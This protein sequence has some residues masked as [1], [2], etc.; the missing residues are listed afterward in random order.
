MTDMVPVFLARTV[1]GLAA[2]EDTLLK[3]DGFFQRQ[4]HFEAKIEAVRL[5]LDRN[6][7]AKTVF[8]NPDAVQLLIA[9]LTAES[10]L[11][12][13]GVDGDG[14]VRRQQFVFASAVL[15]TTDVAMRT[16]RANPPLLRQLWQYVESPTLLDPVQ[17][18][19]WCRCAGGLLLS[20]GDGA[21]PSGG[22]EPPV[23]GLGTLLRHLLRHLHSDAVA[24][25]L[26]CLL[27]VL[28]V[29]G[30]ASWLTLLAGLGRPCDPAAWIRPPPPSTLRPPPPTR[31]DRPTAPAHSAP[32]APTPHDSDAPTPTIDRRGCP[33]P[34]RSVLGEVLPFATELLLYSPECADNAADVLRSVCDAI[35]YH[36]DSAALQQAFLE[37]FAPLLRRTL[38]VCLPLRGPPIVSAGA[39]AVGRDSRDAGGGAG[40]PNPNPGGGRGGGGRGGG[41]GGRGG[42]SGGRGRGGGS[43]GAARVA[44][45]GGGG[46]DSP[47]GLSSPLRRPTTALPPIATSP[48]KSCRQDCG[49]DVGI[50][51]AAEAPPASAAN[52]QFAMSL[53]RAT[54]THAPR[55]RA[56]YTSRRHQHAHTPRKRHAHAT[57]R[58]RGRCARRSSSSR[59]AGRWAAAAATRAT[60]TRARPS[61]GRRWRRR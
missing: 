2:F 9:S 34:L 38:R 21:T 12:G 7:R 60:S 48:P 30:C 14:A 1:E 4:E 22:S 43:P 49:G 24:V 46:V 39:G 32:H 16:I 27:S 35:P 54:H 20:G 45:G 3:R 47:A 25:L 37:S 50:G 61:R 23:A 57:P 52:A 8:A 55:T 51:R 19:Y 18:Q 41:G 28:A 17:L 15:L 31:P 11:D 59:I 29:P 36:E 33:L 44:G 56:M 6:S 13:L 53:V 5:E 10:L 40:Y 58:P 42:S 26:K